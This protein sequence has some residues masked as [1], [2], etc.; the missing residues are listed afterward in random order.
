MSQLPQMH[1][2]DLR[3]GEYTGSRA[4]QL[5]PH[6]EPVLLSGGATPTPPPAAV[7]A[8]HAV[9]WTGAA[10]EVVE[11]HRR[12]MDAQG[13]WVEGSG[14]PYWLPSEGDDW[15]GEPRYMET[16][17]PL[18]EGAV[19]TRPEKPLAV[20]RKEK[21]REIAGGYE[22]A[23]AAALTMPAENPTPTIVAVETSALLA[24]D[25]DAVDSLRAVLDARRTELESAA[26][27]AATVADVEAVVVRYPI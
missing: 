3:T 23:L 27:A 14:T 8:G 6:G 5:R 15:R 19:T 12:T 20:V 25:P 18:P 11:D 2:Y 22:A 21:L 4:A 16:P 13:R 1:E 9:R 26:N 17:G 10:W 24:V 7:P